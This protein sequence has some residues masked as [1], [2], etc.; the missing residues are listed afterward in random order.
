MNKIISIILTFLI[1]WSVAA[2]QE[3][4]CHIGPIT[5]DLAGGNWQVTSCN[6]NHSLVFATMKG[7]PAMPSVFF[8]QRDGETSIIHGEGSGSKEA[9]NYAFEELKKFTE[10]NLDELVDRTKKVNLENDTQATTP[11]ARSTSERP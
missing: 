1:T 8:I 3:L 5:F 6:D 11:H 9:S 7:N 10:S 4:Q 2:E